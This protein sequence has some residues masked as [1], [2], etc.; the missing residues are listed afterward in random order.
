MR[1]FAKGLAGK[2]SLILRDDPAER[3]STTLR[4]GG[5]VAPEGRGILRGVVRLGALLEGR[6]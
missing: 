5:L 1:R 4:S 3:P 6:G 2:R